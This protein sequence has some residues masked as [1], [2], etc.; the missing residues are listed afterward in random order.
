MDRCDP[1]DPLYSFGELI[2]ARRLKEGL[3]PKQYAAKLGVTDF[4]IRN[5]ERGPH[6]LHS[7]VRTLTRLPHTEFTS[8]RKEV[9]KRL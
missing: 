4:T 7:V 2:K 9:L 5:W 1:K 6:N 8:L 3:T